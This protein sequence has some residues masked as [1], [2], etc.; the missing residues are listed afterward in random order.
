MRR[1][2]IR[3]VARRLLRAAGVLGLGLVAL[4]GASDAGAI[5]IS[6]V[7]VAP[8]PTYIQ[9]GDTVQVD[10]VVSGLGDGT[11][12]SLTAFALDIGYTTGVLGFVSFAYNDG[13]G[14][15]NITN[16]LG[17]P[18]TFDNLDSNCD[19]ILEDPA[20]VE[21]GGV[22]SPQATALQSPSVIDS[23]QPASMVLGTIV[24]DVHTTGAASLT[25]NNV[26]L[27]GT[28]GGGSE[29][30][31]SATASGLTLQ[32]PSLPEP[33]VGWLLGLALAGLAA[34]RRRT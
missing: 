20:T 7:A 13:G 29:G 21:S 30:T 32:P 14:A 18:C 24:F 12:P 25:F 3:R 5:S 9:S 34:A 1:Q 22:V 4:M 26:D 16:S 23:Y 17:D 28:L 15:I 8:T 27:A 11:S 33:A 10:I 6:L 2:G 19:V 31:L